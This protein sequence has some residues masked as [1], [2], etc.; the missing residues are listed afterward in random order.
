MTTY[1]YSR[2]DGSQNVFDM[3]EDDIM[4]ALSED[5]LASGDINRALRNLM[6]RGMQDERGQ[7]M[8]GLR[9]QQERLRQ[10]RQQQ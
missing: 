5:I 4:D 2:W 3:D 7:Q 1:R 8:P 6:R 9:D 10:R